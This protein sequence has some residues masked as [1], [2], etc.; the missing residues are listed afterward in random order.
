MKVKINRIV[1]NDGEHFY[2]IYANGTLIKAMWFNPEATEGS[3]AHE[4]VVL[5][6]A[7]ALAFKLEKSEDIKPSETTI[8]ETPD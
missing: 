7:K 2:Y 3:L 6:E 8:Y 5:N 1:K 4:S